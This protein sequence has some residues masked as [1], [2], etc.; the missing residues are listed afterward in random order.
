MSAIASFCRGSFGSETALTAARGKLRAQAD[1]GSRGAQRALDVT[2]D[3]ERLIGSVL[4]VT[5]GQHFTS[6]ATALL[7]KMGKVLLFLLPLL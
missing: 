5:L 6:L 3:S 7:G 4:L 2:E 1:K